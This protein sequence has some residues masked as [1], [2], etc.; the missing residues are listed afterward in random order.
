MNWG[1][2]TPAPGIGVDYWSARF[3]GSFFFSGG[4]FE[5]FVQSDDGTRVYIDNILVIDAW[6]DGY[7]QRNNTFRQVGSGYH[8]MRV[9]YYERTGSAFVRV[10]WSFPGSQAPISGLV[11]PPG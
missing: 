4:D 6:Y 3:E 7:K 11:P 8:M 5:F 2:G 9:D 10:W 1:E